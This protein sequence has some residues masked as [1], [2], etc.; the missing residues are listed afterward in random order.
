MT[1]MY[2]G[3]AHSVKC[4]VCQFVTPISVSGSGTIHGYA[5]ELILSLA[6]CLDLLVLGT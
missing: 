5:A 2:A 4:A 3:G 6:L 1:L